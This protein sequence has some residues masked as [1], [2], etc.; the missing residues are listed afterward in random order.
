MPRR[1]TGHRDEDEQP[2][3]ARQPK[4]PETD[5][6]DLADPH[7]QAGR[8]GKADRAGQH[9]AENPTAIER[10]GGEQVEQQQAEVGKR[11]LLEQPGE[12]KPIRILGEGGP[13][14]QR[15][16]RQA[17]KHERHRRAGE[18]D[19]QL[20]AC[21][22]RWPRQ[23]RDA[24]DR[25][26]QDVGCVDAEPCGHADVAE[27]VKHDRQE[28]HCKKTDGGDRGLGPPRNEGAK[29]IP[30][31]EHQKSDVQ[32]NGGAA[33]PTQ[34]YRPAHGSSPVFVGMRLLVRSSPCPAHP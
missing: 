8:P 22:P 16:D 24:A 21:G 32:A 31:Q 27:L 11:S 30:R 9:S 10:K 23:V 13:V 5:G 29:R 6:G 4:Q 7:C 34:A 1:R 12:G 26:Q 18:R 33:H 25:Q 19:Q 17:E 2:V 15:R 28:Q 14:A 20:L 3:A